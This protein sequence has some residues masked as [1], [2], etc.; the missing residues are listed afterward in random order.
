MLDGWGGGR[1]VLSKSVKLFVA[2]TCVHLG[3]KSSVC[4]CC[5]FSKKLQEAVK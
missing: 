4:A 3:D 2:I 5:K 1:R